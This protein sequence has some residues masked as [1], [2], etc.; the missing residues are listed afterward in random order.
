MLTAPLKRKRYGHCKP[1]NVEM[2]AEFD[3]TS[4]Y[5]KGMK[6]L[7]VCHQNVGRSQMAKAFYNTITGSHDADAAG[8]VVHE[9]GQTLQERKR[10][11]SSKNFFVLDAMAEKGI[12]ISQATR[13][14]LVRKKSDAYDLIVSMENKKDTPRWLLESPKYTFWDV[15]DP[16]GQELE[17]TR[18]IRDDIE[19]RVAGLLRS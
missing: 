3:S 9:P 10:S 16:R 17:R 6:V 2:S 8:T 13:Q 18:E 19:A 4:C 11:S 14:P 7:F 12:D 15:P 1:G 5:T